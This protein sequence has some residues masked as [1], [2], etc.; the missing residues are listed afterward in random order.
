MFFFQKD[1]KFAVESASNDIIFLCLS[2]LNWEVFFCKNQ[3]FQV[4]MIKEYFLKKNV[5]V[6]LKGICNKIGEWKLMALAG[7]LVSFYGVK[8]A[9]T[10]STY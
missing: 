8:Y 1:G 5:F 7:R 2:H 6:L 9:G 3:K 10:K 4:Y